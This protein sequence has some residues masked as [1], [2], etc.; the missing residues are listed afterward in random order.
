MNGATVQH[1]A[2]RLYT[3]YNE[4]VTTIF[5][6]YSRDDFLEATMV[7]SKVVS[8]LVGGGGGLAGLN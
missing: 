1:E 2:T 6:N 7:V 3:I 5:R 4:V 8:M